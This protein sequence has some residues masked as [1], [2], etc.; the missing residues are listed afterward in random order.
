MK[1]PTK[2]HSV[3]S[4]LD[5]SDSIWYHIPRSLAYKDENGKSEP[6][7]VVYYPATGFWKVQ[8]T[9]WISDPGVAQGKGWDSLSDYFGSPVDL[10]M[11]AANLLRYSLEQTSYDFCN[12]TTEEQRIVRTQKNLDKLKVF[13]LNGLEEENEH[14]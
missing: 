6:R 2:R 7:F 13:I 14:E 4:N 9:K 1:T 8:Y 5:D 12:L 10:K 11:I 3:Y